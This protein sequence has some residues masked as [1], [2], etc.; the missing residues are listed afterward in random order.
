MKEIETIKIPSGTKYLSEVK[1]LNGMLPINKIFNKSLVGSGGS[2]IPITSKNEPYVIAVPFV[3][4]INNKLSQHPEIIPVYGKTNKNRNEL[5][6]AI[7]NSDNPKIMVTYDSLDYVTEVLG[8]RVKDFKILIDEYHLL[9]TQY[10]FRDI[11]INKILDNYT[12][13]KS[14]CF[15]TAT[16]LE[17]NFI[18]SKLKHIP[19]V[20]AEWEDKLQVNV[21]SIKLLNESVDSKKKI[22]GLCENAVLELIEKF[23]GNY[24]GFN[25]N[26]YFFVNST[27]F[28]NR[29]LNSTKGI[30]NDDNCRI[31]YSENNDTKFRIKRGYTFD[32]PKK[33]NFLTSTAFEGNDI[34]DT[35]GI[36]FAISSGDN[37]NTLID[38]STSFYQIAGRIRDSKYRDTINHIYT[39]TRYS[40]LTPEEHKAYIDNCIR[41]SKNSVQGYNLIEPELRKT[42]NLSSTY[43]TFNQDTD[44]YEFNEDK[45]LYELYSYSVINNYSLNISTY[46]EKCN[47]INSTFLTINKQNLIPADKKMNDF[48][49]TVIERKRLDKDPYSITGTDKFFIDK[50]NKKYKFLNDAI[51]ML[52]YDKIEEMNYVV[53]SI[54]RAVIQKSDI[55]VEYKIQKMLATSIFI[56]NVYTLKSLKNLLTK[57]YNELKLEK[58]AKASDIEKYYVVEKTTTRVNNEIQKSYRIIS[59]KIYFN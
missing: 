23:I 38:I 16:M 29:I 43:I 59:N 30:L 22:S 27:G 2:F 4:L 26:A 9:F 57:I 49:A 56:N 47:N 58:N 41:I 53:T 42:I 20:V 37:T 31:I 19:V 46:G 55:A 17:D 32:K 11:A 51:N 7:S 8:E 39:S 14:F 21:N 48:K 28:I 18:L 13:Y 10:A 50:S 36:T 52:G 25:G 35:D 40:K 45:V 15:M 24:D 44:K 34:F 3:S 6:S 12:K 33:I 5:N 1:E 54:R